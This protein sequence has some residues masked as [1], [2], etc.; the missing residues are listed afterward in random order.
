[1]LDA[2]G[3]CW[4]MRS[5]INRRSRSQQVLLQPREDNADPDQDLHPD[6]DQDQLNDPVYQGSG[7]GLSDVRG[8]HSLPAA[9]RAK[10]GRP[11]K[12]AVR[13][14]A[15]K[16]ADEA[17]IEDAEMYLGGELGEDEE[18][19][20]AAELLTADAREVSVA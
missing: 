3:F 10:R 12:E 5:E 6:Q 18:E 9:P 1:M 17:L 2:L 19:E 11:T 13:G 15:Q 14:R 8:V 7:L 16:L 20:I 4:E